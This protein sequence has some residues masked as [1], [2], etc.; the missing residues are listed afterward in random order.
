M[1]GR[2]SIYILSLSEF[3]FVE[4]ETYKLMAWAREMNSHC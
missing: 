4:K 1:L 3:T 2:R